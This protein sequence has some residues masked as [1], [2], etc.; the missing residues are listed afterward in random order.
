MT[1]RLAGKTAAI[2]GAA[3][4]IGFAC[5]RALIEEGARV[6]L[7]DRDEQALE[8]ACDTLGDGADALAL[9]LLDGAAVSG[10][11]PALLARLGHLDIFHA[12]AGAYVG[13]DV[14]EGDPSTWD[15]VLNL[16]VNAVFRCVRTV[17]PHMIERQT[18]DV[19]FTSSVAGLVPVTWEPVYTAS[20]FA[21]QGFVHTTR[22]QMIPHGIRVGAVAPGPVIT[23]LIDDW[24]AAKLEEAKAAGA[25][26]EACEVAE[27]VCF[28][29]TRPRGVVIRDLVILPQG[30]DL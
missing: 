21:I 16:N 15:R 8:Q 24:P 13:G 26:M 18:G 22:R 1:Q 28:M 9:D 14:S 5:A 25:L 27:A 3:A 2:T 11:M 29:L 20:K 6:V 12:N 19:M 30:C 4:G 17:L 23:S 7:I 10:M